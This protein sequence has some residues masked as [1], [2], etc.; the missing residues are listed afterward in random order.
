MSIKKE[1]RNSLLE[2]EHF[3][4]G[5]FGTE[6]VLMNAF[7]TLPPWFS[8]FIV[9]SSKTPNFPLPQSLNVKGLGW[10][11][12]QH[13]KEYLSSDFETGIKD[14]LSCPVPPEKVLDACV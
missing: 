14:C 8:A 5:T 11:R 2:M 9:C 6:Q 13:F 3:G 4:L 10:P 12:S 1:R 7:S